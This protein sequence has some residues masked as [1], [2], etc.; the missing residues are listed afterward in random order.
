MYGYIIYCTFATSISTTLYFLQYFR[1]T[2]G[3]RNNDSVN[4]F[5]N[6]NHFKITIMKDF[7]V[8]GKRVDFNFH[9]PTSLDEIDADYLFD[10]TRNVEIAEHH[11]LVAIVYHEKLFNIIVS[12]KRKDKN[13]TAGVVPIFIRAGKNDSDFIKTADCKDKLII[14]ST[15]LSLAHHVAAPKNVLSLD[16]FIR[17]IDSDANLARRY[18]NNYGNEECFFVEF[19]II[20]NNEIK[21]IYKAAPDVDSKKYVETSVRS[22]GDC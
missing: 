12:R 11:S 14:P 17:A 21:G 10:V 3:A 8:Q 22:G 19:K 15:S 9:F 2:S 6:I 1:N 16:Y 13:L 20:P 4:V 5:S 7:L 18:D